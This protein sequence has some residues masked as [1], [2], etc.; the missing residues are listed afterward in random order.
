[1]R[2][3][4]GEDLS[5]INEINKNNELA[6]SNTDP[7]KK[8]LS[9]KN[10]ADSPP[11]GNDN[12]R[13]IVQ[14][15]IEYVIT[16]QENLYAQLDAIKGHLHD[17]SSII[18]ILTSDSIPLSKKKIIASTLIESYEDGNSITEGIKWIKL[19]LKDQ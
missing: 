6:G 2:V 19:I 11:L 9:F 14:N 10:P 8:T 1:M 17:S 15:A 12:D 5:L 7:P 16:E 3:N 13:K 18:R 4:N